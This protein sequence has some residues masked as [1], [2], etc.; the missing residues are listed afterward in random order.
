MRPTSLPVPS[1]T[2]TPSTLLSHH[3]ISTDTP[4]LPPNLPHRT[5]KHA[6]QVSSTAN[7]S[8]HRIHANSQLTNPQSPHPDRQRDRAG[9]RVRL[10]GTNDHLPTPSRAKRSKGKPTAAR[11][12]QNKAKRCEWLPRKYR[13]RASTASLFFQLARSL[14]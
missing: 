6:D 10:Q 14:T 13:N 3:D 8:A 12:K 1:N 9:H 7:T 4:P 2:A 11:E 5:R